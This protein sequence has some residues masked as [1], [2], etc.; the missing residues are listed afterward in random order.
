LQLVVL[1]AGGFVAGSLIMAVF[2][3]GYRAITGG[4]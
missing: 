1:F 2:M 4:A 3:L